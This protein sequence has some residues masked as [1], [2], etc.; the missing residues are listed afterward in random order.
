M[1]EVC[2]NG[3]GL[4]EVVLRDM[5]RCELV[6]AFHLVDASAQFTCPRVNVPRLVTEFTRRGVVVEEL[7]TVRNSLEDAFL[8]LFSRGRR[9]ANE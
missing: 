9:V 4:C 8:R 6:G 2:V 5:Q 1:V 3:Q 7:H